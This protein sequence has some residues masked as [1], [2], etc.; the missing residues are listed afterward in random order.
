MREF[1]NPQLR[2]SLARTIV[3]LANAILEGRTGLVVSAP[4]MNKMLYQIGVRDGDESGDAF[5]LISSETDHL[6]VA[7]ERRYWE[8]AALAR[9]DEEIARAELWAHEFG[10]RACRELA[11]RFAAGASAGHGA[12]RDARHIAP[13]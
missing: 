3:A 9:K 1:P 11:A 13:E 12:A 6:P 7:H 8:P 4:R 2:A 5:R 10:L